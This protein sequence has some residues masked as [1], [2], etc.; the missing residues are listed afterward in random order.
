MGLLSGN[1]EAVDKG[2][3]NAVAVPGA[4]PKSKTAEYQRN[5]K[6]KIREGAKGLLKSGYDF[7]EIDK[8]FVEWLAR[9]PGSLPRTSVFGTPIITKIFGATPAVGQTV[10]LRDV[11]NK[12]AH[13]HPQMVSHMKK[14]KEK[15]GLEIKYTPNNEDGKRADSTYTI[16]NLG[17]FK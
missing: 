2:F 17:S 8:A 9:E 14:W 12:T 4:K 3:T 10:T 11:F 5:L 16:V 15:Y 1:D 6:I 13:G 7:N